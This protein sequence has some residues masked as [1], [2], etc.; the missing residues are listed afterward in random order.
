MLF[1]CALVA[2]AG[3]GELL[4]HT[5]WARDAVGQLTG[6]GAF[7]GSARGTSFFQRDMTDPNALTTIIAENL[8]QSAADVA[9]PESEIAHQFDLLRDQFADDA[10]FHAALEKSRLTEQSLRDGIADHLAVRGWIEERIAPEL[11]VTEAECR[12]VYRSNAAQSLQ[13]KRYRAAHLFLA[14]PDGSPAELIAEK[15]SIA[16]GLAV[17]LLAGEAFADL[18]AEESEDEATKATGGDLGYFSAARVPPE[19]LAEIAKL[20]VGNTSP[21]FR[22][23]LGFHIV[24]LTD[25]KPEHALTFEEARPEIAAAI[26]NRKRATAVAQLASSASLPPPVSQRP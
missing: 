5:T 22:S 1:V 2:G 6:R 8:R 16:E 7:V 12:D 21:P 15:R 10:A 13:P 25:T 23:H 4:R 18:A 26:A 3:A 20:A 11:G 14:A 24:Q 9:A 19:F 17:R